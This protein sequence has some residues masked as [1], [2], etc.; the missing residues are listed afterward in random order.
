MFCINNVSATDHVSNMATS[1][2][3]NENQMPQYRTTF[4]FP[5]NKDKE[6]IN[7]KLVPARF[8]ALRFYQAWG[9]G[10]ATGWQTPV[11]PPKVL[12]DNEELKVFSVFAYEHSYYLNGSIFLGYDQYAQY[13]IAALPLDRDVRGAKLIIEGTYQQVAYI[14]AVVYAYYYLHMDNEPAIYNKNI[15][16]QVLDKEMTTVHNAC[17]PY[18]AGNPSVF[19]YPAEPVQKKMPQVPEFFNYLRQAPLIP[20]PSSPINS[21][22]GEASVFRLDKH[23]SKEVVADDIADDGCSRAYLFSTIDEQEVAVLRIKVPEIFID[24]DETDKTFDNYQARYFSVGAHRKVPDGSPDISLSYWT[25]NAR[26]LKDYQDEQGYAYVFFA[27]NWYT[28]TVALKQNTPETQPPV[29]KWGRYKGYLLG[30]PDYAII[31][32]YRDPSPSWVGSPENAKCYATANRVKPVSKDELQEYTP[33]VFADSLDS[34]LQGEIGDV[35]QFAPWP[36]DEWR[37]EE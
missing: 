3:F 37:Q 24:D 28:H 4:T 7:N 10:D 6:Q 8:V 9:E 19:A 17:H 1:C 34:F 21:D 35:S 11:T 14:S 22:T 5:L 15:Q 13:F 25:V 31:M 20:L 30:K 26:M 16:Q 18:V 2:F 32:R 33:E 29:L 12:L 23:T 36:A 27:P